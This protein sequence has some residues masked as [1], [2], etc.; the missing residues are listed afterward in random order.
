MNYANFLLQELIRLLLVVVALL[1]LGVAVS[2]LPLIEKEGVQSGKPELASGISQ[3]G[4]KDHQIVFEGITVAAAGEEGKG[5]LDGKED[6]TPSDLSSNRTRRAAK[7]QHRRT[8]P[9]LL[10]PSGAWSGL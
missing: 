3:T 4:T 7:K 8:I 5:S 9:R 2:S 6:K 10:S 1:F